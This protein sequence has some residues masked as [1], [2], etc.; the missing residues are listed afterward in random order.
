MFLYFAYTRWSGL[1]SYENSFWDFRVF[2]ELALLTVTYLATSTGL[3]AAYI[4]KRCHTLDLSTPKPAN[5]IW[6]RLFWWG[7][8]VVWIFCVGTRHLLGHQEAF[9]TFLVFFGIGICLLFF[10]ACLVI[11][12]K[13]WKAR[14]THGL[15]YGTLARSLIPVYACA[16]IFIGSVCLPWLQKQE[17][18]LLRQDTLFA[19]HPQG[20]TVIEGQLTQ[21]LTTE[22]ADALK[23]AQDR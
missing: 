8:G 22:L 16:A 3:A 23:A 19:P 9:E 7:L 15:Y 6:R 14:R 11:F 1:S 18:A 5:P 10:L 13:G 2:L 20:F 4:R 21:R 12:I 17:S